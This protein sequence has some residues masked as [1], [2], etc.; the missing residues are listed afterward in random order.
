MKPTIYIR[1][2]SYTL[3]ELCLVFFVI[4]LSGMLVLPMIA[5]SVRDWDLN[6]EAQKMC[7]VVR[8]AQ[9]LAESRQMICRV[10]FDCANENYKIMEEAGFYPLKQGI[11]IESTSFTL[12][13]ADTLEFDVQGR[14]KQG[15]DII[16]KDSSGRQKYL[17]VE[18][19]TGFVKVN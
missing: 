9:K 3:L 17:W 1:N 12:P 11:F 10:F 8:E 18:E 13:A 15:G 4:G 19:Q 14:P 16:L 2:Q 5:G 7:M 6:N